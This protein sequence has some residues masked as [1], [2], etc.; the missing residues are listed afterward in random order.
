MSALNKLYSRFLSRKTTILLITILTVLYLLGALIPQKQLLSPE[1]YQAWRVASP[2]LLTF[3]ETFKFTTMYSSP[4][5]LLVTTL[6]F[7]HLILVNW[8]RIPLVAKEI[9][10][11]TSAVVNPDAITRLNHVVL[12][13]ADAGTIAAL[14]VFFISRRYH[15]TAGDQTFKAVKNRYSPIG[16]LVF[17]LSFVPVLLGTLIIFHTRFSG[18]AYVAEGQF[19]SGGSSEYKIRRRYSDLRTKLP[20]V[21]FQVE[22]FAPR[23]YDLDALSLKTSLAV[24]YNGRTA[25]GDCDVN[26][27]FNMDSLSILIADLGAAPL[28]R[29]LDSDGSTFAEGYTLLN[30]IRG[31]SDDYV[32]P[33]TPYTLRLKMWPDYYLG[34]DGKSYTKTFAFNNPRFEVSVF[35]EGKLE[36]EGN[37]IKSPG[38][39][40]HFGSMRLLIPDIR[41]YGKFV[42][43]EEHGGAVLIVGFLLM[44]SGL[45]LKVFWRKKTVSGV[46]GNSDAGNS[47]TIAYQVEHYSG[48][49]DFELNLL[50]TEIVAADIGLYRT[51]K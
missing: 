8:Q 35:R 18:D 33:G 48:L 21:T 22:R 47:I 29:I 23:F 6:F 5:V 13:G 38:D 4:V 31:T 34:A 32:V 7:I 20:D 49:K 15:V 12:Q 11:S 17:H 46:I 27:P 26:R 1:N 24:T 2:L 44:V 10:S 51:D 19:F 50:A 41:Y 45:M 30:I 14:K 9:K 39:A 16:S 43:V 42:V 25:R 3:L 37:I 36:S 28:F 40:V